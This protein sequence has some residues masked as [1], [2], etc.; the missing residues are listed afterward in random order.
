MGVGV[1]GRGAGG[2]AG[3]GGASDI[4]SFRLRLLCVEKCIVPSNRKMPD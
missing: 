4:I 1:G 2:Q 3:K